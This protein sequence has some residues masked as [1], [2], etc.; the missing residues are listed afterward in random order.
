MLVAPCV[1]VVI[2]LWGCPYRLVSSDRLIV[3]LVLLSVLVVVG[4]LSPQLPKSSIMCSFLVYDQ[5]KDKR[6]TY[7]LSR[8]AHQR[9]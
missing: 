8:L 4:S 1:V 5:V 6:V 3:T 2:W 7:R 9:V